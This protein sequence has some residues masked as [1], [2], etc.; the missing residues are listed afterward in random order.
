MRETASCC[1]FAAAML[2]SPR[3]TPKIFHSVC[4]KWNIGRSESSYHVRRR[5]PPARTH[6]QAFSG[7]HINGCHLVVFALY[8]HTKPIYC[9]IVAGSCDTS[10]FLHP[11]LTEVVTD[12]SDFPHPC[13]LLTAIQYQQADGCELN[14]DRKRLTEMMPH[15]KV[16]SVST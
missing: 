13:W 6:R 11:V 1:C 8:V 10:D 12:L 4:P 14:P 3:Q 7:L 9:L 5:I 2:I 16:L 15:N